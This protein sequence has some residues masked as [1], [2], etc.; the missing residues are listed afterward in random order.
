MLAYQLTDAQAAQ[1]Q[2]VKYDSASYFF[3]Q[4]DLYDRWVILEIEVKCNQN[5]AVA[6]VANLPCIG[7]FQQKPT[8][9]TL[10][11]D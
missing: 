9:P 10:P 11:I 1:L 5:P 8:P 6:W 2:G 3:P 7:E 4:R